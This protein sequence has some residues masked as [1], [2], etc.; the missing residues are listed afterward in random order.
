MDD[1]LFNYLHL[2]IV[3]MFNGPQD[4]NTNNVSTSNLTIFYLK[5]IL[6]VY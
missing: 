5:N 3:H 6:H 2:E 1:V 4:G